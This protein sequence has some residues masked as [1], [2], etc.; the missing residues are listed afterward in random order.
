M[1]LIIYY[2]HSMEMY[3]TE[4]EE[5][6]LQRLEE[7]FPKG[8]VF[9]PNRPSVQ[10]SENPMKAC[11]QAVKDSHILAFSH[12]ARKIPLGVYAEMQLARKLHKPIYIINSAE[13]HRY[14]GHTILTKRRKASDWAQV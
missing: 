10:Q 1:I 4:R 11:F 13:I 14:A 6:D 8:L 12:E 3:N 2:A 5:Q 7:Y 9:N